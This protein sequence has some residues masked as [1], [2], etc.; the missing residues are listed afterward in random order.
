MIRGTTPTE[1]FTVNNPEVIDLSQC[2]QIWA[3]ITDNSGKDYTWDLERL[4]V[5]G[6][7]ISLELTQTE[8]LAFKVG[9]ARAQLRFLYNDGTAFA[10]KPVPL[11]IEDVR[12]DGV[13]S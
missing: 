4:V 2:S 9:A 6:D 7:E 12:K 13:I 10:S 11:R 8:T 1:V 5:N 3:T